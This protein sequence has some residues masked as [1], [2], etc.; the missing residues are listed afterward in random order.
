MANRPAMPTHRFRGKVIK[1]L[2]GLFRGLSFV[3]GITAPSPEEDEAAFVFV[4]L[5]IFAV[6]IV[7]CALIF[8]VISHMHVP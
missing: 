6:V 2:A 8:Y 1:F 7:F 5:A 4:W 3:V